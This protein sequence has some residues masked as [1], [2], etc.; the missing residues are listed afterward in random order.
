MSNILRSFDKN[1]LILWLPAGHIFRRSLE[2]HVSRS[3]YP[4][5]C[6]RFNEFTPIISCPAKVALEAHA[7]LPRIPLSRGL[8]GYQ[9]DF[10]IG[11]LFHSHSKY[12]VILVSALSSGGRSSMQ[13]RSVF[14]RQFAKCLPGAKRQSV[15]FRN[16]D[17]EGELE[18]F[19]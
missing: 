3:S 11:L 10:K 2:C 6:L 4:R 13:K 1:N 14:G 5:A 12:H 17:P 8:L 19:S 16:F 7:S 18:L 9:P 15:A